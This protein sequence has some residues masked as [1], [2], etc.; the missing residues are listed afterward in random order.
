MQSSILCGRYI[1]RIAIS[2]SNMP[3]ARDIVF[4]LMYLL[5][6]KLV[7]FLPRENPMLKKRIEIFQ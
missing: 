5:Y 6:V 7:I 3:G 2:I 4:V 1:L